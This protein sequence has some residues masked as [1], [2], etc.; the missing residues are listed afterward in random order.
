MSIPNT[1][2]NIA[3]AWCVIGDPNSNSIISISP[4][5]AFHTPVPTSQVHTTITQRL[6]RR[7]FGPGRPLVTPRNVGWRRVCSDEEI[8]HKYQTSSTPN[9]RPRPTHAPLI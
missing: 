3:S 5:L 4:P 1:P 9:P 8:T 6:T 2:S 7:K